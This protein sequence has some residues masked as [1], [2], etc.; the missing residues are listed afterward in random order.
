MGLGKASV[1][2]ETGVETGSDSFLVVCRAAEWLLSQG[3]P[4]LRVA[5]LCRLFAVRKLFQHKL[6]N[7]MQRP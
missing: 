5:F 2:Q 1:L 7:F 3:R 6:G 4:A